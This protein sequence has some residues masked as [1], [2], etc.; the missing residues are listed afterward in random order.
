MGWTWLIKFCWGQQN[1]ISQVCPS[2]ALLKQHLIYF[3][4]QWYYCKF[5]AVYCSVSWTSLVQSST[6]KQINSHLSLEDF[7]LQKMLWVTRWPR[8]CGYKTR[9]YHH[10]FTTV[11]HSSYE[12][13][14]IINSDKLCNNKNFSVLVSSVERTWFQKSRGSLKFN[15]ESLAV[16]SFWGGLLY[17]FILFIFW[18]SNFPISL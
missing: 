11:L 18:Y 2:S 17:Y 6:V 4:F 3:L 8:S 5:A 1:F 13:F 12:A 15:I 7:F 10:I 16:M 14:L 9:S